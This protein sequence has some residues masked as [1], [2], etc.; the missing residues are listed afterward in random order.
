MLAY[1]C[2]DDDGGSS[3]KPVTGVSITADKTVLEI[4]H[5]SEITAVV[6]GD[7]KNLTWYVND[8]E[9][10]NAVY[11]TITH[12]S[13]VTYNA[14]DS[15]PAE[16]TVYI[17]AVSDE[18][19]AIADTVSIDLEFN[20]VFVKS[21][22]GNDNTATGSV[23]LPAKTI[24]KGLTLAEAGMT[25][26][27]FPGLYDFYNGEVFELAIPESVALVGMDWENCKIIGHGTGSY[28]ASVLMDERGSSFRKFTLEMGEPEEEAWEVAIH[29]RDDNQL[30]DSIRV[31]E[32]GVYAVLRA[33]STRNSIVRNCHF[34]V[35]DGETW[36]KGY[37]IT[38]SNQDFI[39][40]TCTASGFSDAVFVNGVQDPLIEG[41]SLT[42]NRY[43]LQMWYQPPSSNPNPDLGGGAR[44]SA[45]GNDLSGNSVC[46]LN[47]LSSNTV[48][49]MYNT[50]NN[51][52]PVEGV[53][54]CNSGTGSVITQ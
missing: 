53:D 52:P 15:L 9:N 46:G 38:G 8:I 11:G 51:S 42:G 33:T 20:K 45:G 28:N 41:C 5:I 37:E 19:D 22:I 26:L 50:W 3:P 34:A 32:R 35:D 39:L 40:R 44:G 29:M 36:H 47:N 2:G 1:G 10:G 4:G 21:D 43:G 13:P 16:A 25:V 18:D 24:T 48:Y 54:Y 12:N 14:P 31:F 30:V 6:T 27:V 7:N 49:A 17:V 23:N